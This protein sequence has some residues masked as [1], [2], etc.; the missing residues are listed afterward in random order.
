M[1]KF[2]QAVF[3]DYLKPGTILICQTGIEVVLKIESPLKE[4]VNVT[5]L[6]IT[7]SSVSIRVDPF[8]KGGYYI[9]KQMLQS[10]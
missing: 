4:T 2:N 10:D 5:V 9:N 1:L 8:F 3:I 7:N 6:D